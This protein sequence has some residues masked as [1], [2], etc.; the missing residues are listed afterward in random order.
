[1]PFKNLNIEINQLNKRLF[2]SLVIA[3]L[4]TIICNITRK[5]TNFLLASACGEYKCGRTI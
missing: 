5:F 3:I 1:M 4:Y 2:K